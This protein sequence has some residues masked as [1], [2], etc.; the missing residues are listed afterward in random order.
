MK[1][2]YVCVDP[3]IALFGRKGASVHVQEMIREFR[4]A[5]H[6]V[7]AYVVRLGDDVPTDLEDLPVTHIKIDKAPV[8]QREEL[9]MQAAAT[10]AEHILRDGADFIYE[11][12][13]LFSDVLARTNLPSVLEVNA[14]LIDEQRTHRELHHEDTAWQRLA[15]QVEAARATICV[16]DMVTDWVLSHVS[17]GNAHKVHTVPNGVST[18]RITPQPAQ[19]HPSV[20]TFVG[21]LKPWHGTADAIRAA[22]LKKSDW[23]LRIIG[24]GPERAELEAL[25]DELGVEVDFRGAVPPADMPAHLA[26]SSIGI[27]P[28]PAVDNEADQYFSPLKVYEYMAAGL[29]VVASRVGQIPSIIRDGETGVLTQPSNPEE[30]AN[31]LDMLVDA[32]EIRSRMGAVGRRQAIEQHSWTMIAQKILDLAGAH[33]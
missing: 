11:R 16:S 3:G 13:S 28:Y 18:S 19:E 20:A 10:I 23:T 9:T 6:D 24:D 8:K 12:Y 1:I 25:A 15:Q 21:T 27:A 29:P 32:P 33:V 22:A 17:A 5:G 26:G 7:H 2:A 31:V 30:L 4:A 14:P